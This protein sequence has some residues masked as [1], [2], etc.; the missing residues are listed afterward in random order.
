MV[1]IGKRKLGTPHPS[2]WV[3]QLRTFLS[4]E[5]APT[6]RKLRGALRLTTIGTV[7]AGAIAS[8][9]IHSEVG[10]YI[11]WLLVGAGPMMTLRTAVTFLVAEAASLTGAVMM[12]RAL[13]ETPWL[14]LCFLFLLFSFS[15]YLGTVW[16]LGAPL[17]L[18]E[19][20]VLD[21]FYGVVFAPQQI[22][23]DAAN[24]FGGSVIAFGV[25]VLFDNWLWPDLGEGIL[26]KALGASVARSRVRYLGATG[27]YLDHEGARRP[28][29]PPATSDLPAH[30]RLLDQ[31]VAEGVSAHRR[32]VLL[33][34]ITRAARIALEVDRLIFIG[35][36]AVRREIRAMVRPELESAVG[37]IAYALD[38]F[39]RVLPSQ[40]PVGADKPPPSSG[41]R[42]RIAMDDLSARILQVRPVYLR[43]SSPAEIENFAS[44]TNSLEV[45]TKLI[46]RLL[47]EPPRVPDSSTAKPTPRLTSPPDPAVIRYSLKVGLCVVVGYTIGIVAH[48]EDLSTILTTV[49]ITALPTYGA[50]LRKM[51]L[52]IIGATIGGAISLLTIILVSPN[53]ETLPAYMIAVFVVFYISAYSS[54]GS[55]RIAYA[56]KQIGTTFALVFAGLGPSVE[57]YEPL[58]RI[59][60]ILL[61]TLVAGTIDF[62]V[63]PEYAG[64]SLLPRLRTVVGDTLALTPGGAAAATEDGIQRAN[65]NTM[66]VLEEILGV[67]EDAQIEGRTSLVDHSAIVEAASYLRRIANRLSY[68]ANGRI[69]A[70]SPP[71]DPTTE[72]A[73]AD[74]FALVRRQLQSWLDLLS[75]PNALSGE[76]ARTIAQMH[77]ADDLAGPVN[78][79]ALRLEEDKFSRLQLWTT[80]RRQTILAELQ[81]MRRLEYLM[82][83]LNRWLAQVPGRASTS[84]APIQQ[85]QDIGPVT[86]RPE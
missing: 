1:S 22:G 70:P 19:V 45:L 38:D 20:V 29:I 49:L 18:I 74:A 25:M 65:S 2:G 71:L 5:L 54:L 13:A 67:A 46:E 48:R 57:I 53:F 84:A 4:R 72:K 6:S 27:F 63:W 43:T 15:T 32:A 79:F 26:M 23:W 82:P 33:A 66:R 12:A 31:A 17:L 35:R 7:G 34:A 73:R 39:A 58:W 24:A 37:A 69:I 51:I 8:A 47:D 55:G 40:I 78:Q 64:D 77:S 41:T 36:Q 9:H 81:S 85:R 16:K 68:I 62:I 11:V 76:A 50:S 56:G 83:E 28:P 14:M 44:F 61:G 42:A 30:L 86:V 21:T 52:R 10:T 80:D 3:D 59:W 75:G 60:S